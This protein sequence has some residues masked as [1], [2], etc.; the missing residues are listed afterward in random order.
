MFVLAVLVCS[1]L[2]ADKFSA[3]MVWPYETRIS[4]GNKCYHRMSRL[5]SRRGPGGLDPC[6][7]QHKNGSTLFVV[8]YLYQKCFSLE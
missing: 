7:I 1:M 3:H 5:G 6:P 2:H 4:S 8:L